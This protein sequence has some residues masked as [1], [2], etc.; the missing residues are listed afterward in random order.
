MPRVNAQAMPA[1]PSASSPAEGTSAIHHQVQERELSGTAL[2]RSG[3]DL[4]GK[5]V[6]EKTSDV[7]LFKFTTA[8]GSVTL[9]VNVASVGATLDA[10]LVV[11]NGAGALVAGVREVAIVAGRG[12]ADYGTAAGTLIHREMV[13][14]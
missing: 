10:R 7:D 9:N 12:V 2:T 5:G 3:S 14:T 6:I 1:R 13:T 11:H 4:S 8:G